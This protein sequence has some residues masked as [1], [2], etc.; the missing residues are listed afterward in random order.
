[1]G[2]KSCKQYEVDQDDNKSITKEEFKS[3]SSKPVAPDVP[4]PVEVYP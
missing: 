1:M 4:A 2:A 3:K